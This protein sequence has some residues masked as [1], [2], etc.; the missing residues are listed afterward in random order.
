MLIN[1]LFL[2]FILLVLLLTFYLHYFQEQIVQLLH[3]Q[4]S[5]GIQRLKYYFGIMT[6]IGILLI[7]IQQEQLL[8]IWLAI[9]TCSI[10]PL[11]FIVMR[12]MK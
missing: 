12:Q 11:P 4:H 7:I 9:C 5:S 6:L 10:I 1:L 8:L 2:L 3:L